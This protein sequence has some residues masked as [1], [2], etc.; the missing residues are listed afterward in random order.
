MEGHGPET[1]RQDAGDVDDRGELVVGTAQQTVVDL[2]VHA[3][4]VVLDPA[5]HGRPRQ[6]PVVQAGAGGGRGVERRGRRLGDAHVVAVAVTAGRVEGDDEM[7][8]HAPH[9][10]GDELDDVPDRDAHDHADAR[11]PVPSAVLV[12]KQHDLGD[13][14]RAGGVVELHRCGRGGG[15]SE[16]VRSSAAP[17][18]SPASRH[19]LGPPRAPDSYPPRRGLRSAG[20]ARGRE[21]WPRRRRRARPAPRARRPRA[22]GSA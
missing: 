9:G 15:W 13:A 20:R 17:P 19:G 5:P 16:P 10:V 11:R 18:C 22:S 3:A 1:P 7:G 2:G 8:G 4:G 21:W 12:G 14:E 6:A